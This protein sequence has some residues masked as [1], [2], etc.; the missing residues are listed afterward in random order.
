MFLLFRKQYSET[1]MAESSITYK[2]VFTIFV[3]E[4]EREHV[5]FLRFVKIIPFDVNF[6][7]AVVV[8]G[9]VGI[10]LGWANGS[11]AIFEERF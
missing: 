6:P 1:F 11:M 7:V 5:L 9:S 3:V 10:R 4:E 2:S 8:R